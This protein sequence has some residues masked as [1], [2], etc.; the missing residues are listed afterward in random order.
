MQAFL[1]FFSIT[2]YESAR[3]GRFSLTIFLGQTLVRDCCILIGAHS[4][5]LARRLSS[6][7][8]PGRMFMLFR[9]VALRLGWKSLA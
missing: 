3:D 8:L 9:T 1:G 4:P 2:F 5:R 7:C 6:C